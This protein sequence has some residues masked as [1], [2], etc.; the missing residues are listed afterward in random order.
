MELSRVEIAEMLRHWIETGDVACKRDLPFG[1]GKINRAI[2]K[3][4]LF[5]SSFE[6][7]VFRNERYRD[8]LEAWK[9]D[10]RVMDLAMVKASTRY[11]TA[12]AVNVACA[13]G[14][15]LRFPDFGK[16]KILYIK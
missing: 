7:L 1:Y 15:M 12:Y 4:E 13:N 16:S 2:G 10:G 11:T 9:S 8:M 5:Q 6:E 14:K 3:N